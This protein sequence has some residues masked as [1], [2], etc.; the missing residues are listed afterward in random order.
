MGGAGD[1]AGP[2]PDAEE[3]IDIEDSEDEDEEEEDGDD[4]MEMD[5]AAE[6]A[7][8]QQKAP[9]AQQPHAGAGGPDVMVH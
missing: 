3:E 2:K 9:G 8:N 1:T 6:G 5:D 7:N 4:D